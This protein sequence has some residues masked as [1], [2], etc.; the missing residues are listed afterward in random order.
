MKYYTIYGERCSGTNY[1]ENLMKLNFN[2]EYNNSNGNKHFFGHID[3]FTHSEDTLFICIVRNLPDWV[4]SLYR[5]LYH[6]PLK[7]KTGLSDVQKID[8]FL[9]QQFFSINDFQHNYKSWSKEIMDDRNIYTGNRYKNIYELRHTKLKYMI[10]DLPKKVHNCI[11]I[12][13]DDLLDDFDNV[14]FK[15]KATGLIVKPEVVFP[16][17]TFLY[18]K[19][20]NRVF[21]KNAYKQIIS[22]AMIVNN[23]N[24]IKT[25]EEHLGFMKSPPKFT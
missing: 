24:L 17:N 18:K 10:E 16:L 25:Y 12:K 22:P 19:D 20:P 9:N 13:Y 3:N 8:E 21:V 23:P 7:Y 1:L 15:L 14:M 11:L 5:E 6:L 2:I 4:N